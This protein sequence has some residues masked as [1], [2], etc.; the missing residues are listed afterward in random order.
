M[1][2]ASR[3]RADERTDDPSA[4]HAYITRRIAPQTHSAHR[5]SPSSSSSSISSTRI[6]VVHRV[7]SLFLSLPCL[8]LPS[9]HYYR[10]SF[11]FFF[12]RVAFFPALFSSHARFSI[13]TEARARPEFGG[14]EARVE[15]RRRVRYSREIAKRTVSIREEGHRQ[16]V[17]Q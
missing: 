7:D 2:A 5:S 4:R 11:I 8:A 6:I 10:R 17:A 9:C 14:G 15:T 1:I 16:L 13:K 12:C 3:R